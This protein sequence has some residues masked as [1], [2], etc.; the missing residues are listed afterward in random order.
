L[1]LLALNPN[2]V[3]YVK[4]TRMDGLCVL[5]TLLGLIAYVR[6]RGGD[7]GIILPAAGVCFALAVLTHPLG[8][9]GPA[10]AGSHA[11]IDRE[12][13][14][15]GSLRTLLLI[16]GPAAL[17]AVVWYLVA[18]SHAEFGPQAAFQLARKARPF[19]DPILA[20]AERYRSIPVFGLLIPAGLV[21]AWLHA[22]R[23]VSRFSAFVALSATIS[24]VVVALSFEYSYHV[25]FL[26]YISIACAEFFERLRGGERMR[27][28][29]LVWEAAVLCNFGAYFL[30]FNYQFHDALRGETDYAAFA[31]RVSAKIPPGS[32]VC[33][34][35]YPCLYWGL[36]SSDRG[37]RLY[38][39]TFLS[40]SLAMDLVTKTGWFVAVDGLD[41][42][43]SAGV[44]PQV[45]AMKGY[46]A[47]CGKTCVLREF[48][49]ERRKFSYTANIFELVPSRN[50]GHAAVPG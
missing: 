34:S 2:F 14:W 1:L 4:L 24:I 31:G 28:I 19:P 16:A 13:S 35:G 33:I 38:G 48:V 20:F 7:K 29:V 8:I 45:Q 47:R 26:P 32:T 17:S 36:V 41:P 12:R 44:A 49:G 25:Y 46:A 10:I 18:G 6:Y 9:I 37:Y 21:S 27:P 15:Q 3:T 22:S 11:L 42:N 50:H 30:F 5:L 23:K 43:D 40:D 39:D